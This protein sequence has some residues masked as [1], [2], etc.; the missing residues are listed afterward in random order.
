[1]LACLEK[2]CI[3]NV[4]LHRRLALLGGLAATITSRYTSIFFGK[5]QS[6]SLNRARDNA[7]SNTL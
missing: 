1:M 4:C 2:I 5:L 7:I 3:I 6:R